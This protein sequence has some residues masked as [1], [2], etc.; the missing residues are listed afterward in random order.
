[1]T[2]LTVK[3]PTLDEMRAVAPD[4]LRAMAP[5]AWHGRHGRRVE[6]CRRPRTEAARLESAAEI[7]AGG[8]RLLGAL[9]AAKERPEL[10]QLPLVQVLRQ[11]PA[12]QH[13]AQV[14][15]DIRGAG[16]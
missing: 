11:V 2:T 3:T 13:V 9:D 12:T 1:M 5:A 16:Q 8:Q 10:A 4:W 14:S 15:G 6:N 7:G